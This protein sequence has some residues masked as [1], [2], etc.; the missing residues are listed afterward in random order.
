MEVQERRI[1]STFRRIVFVCFHGHAN[2]A[3]WFDSPLRMWMRNGC[4]VDIIVPKNVNYCN[5]PFSAHDGEVFLTG[6]P[7][8]GVP[9]RVLSF[10]F[11]TISTIRRQ[12]YSLIVAFDQIA[13]IAAGVAWHLFRIPYLYQCLELRLAQETRGLVRTALKRM[14]DFY[15]RR[16]ILSIVH[17][18]LRAKLLSVD[19][20]VPFSAVV[21]VPNSPLGPANPEKCSYLRQ[22]LNIPVESTIVLCAGSLARETKILE[23]AAYTPSWPQGFVLVLNGWGRPEY[24]K[25]VRDFAQMS[26][27]RILV[28]SDLLPLDLIDTL[29]ASADI[30]IALYGRESL[31]TRFVG[32]SAG[33]VFYYLKHGIPV[34]ASDLP[35]LRSVIERNRVGICVRNAGEIGGALTE[36]SMHYAEYRENAFAAFEK[37]E[38]SRWYKYVIVKAERRI[39]SRY[40]MQDS[41]R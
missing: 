17:G 4:V 33:K 37:Y 9:R 21:S 22:K 5:I 14:E 27:G 25:A 26:D 20:K 3:T 32:E 16:A 29:F 2:L 11:Q 41:K 28:A 23:I 38:F 6:H 36:I 35:E 31:N 7:A 1:A 15:I 30:G 18:D 8:Q 24:I 34:I 40:G 12:K 10:V 13:V 39:K 19:S